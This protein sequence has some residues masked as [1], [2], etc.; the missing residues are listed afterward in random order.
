M[1]I[2]RAA[3]GVAAAVAF[4]A[5]AALAAAPAWAAPST[6]VVQSAVLRIVSVADWSEAADLLPGES[7]Q[8]DVTVSADADAEPGTVTLALSAT[9][10]APLLVDAELC[11]QPW[12]DGACPGGASVLLTSWAIPRDGSEAV[13]VDFPSTQ[14]AHLR[15]RMAL[16]GDDDRPGFT[17]VR[18][19]AR[20]VGDA[21]T[22]GAG[23]GLAV[24]GGTAPVGA[25]IGGG[26]LLGA[27]TVL[28]AG[29]IRRRRAENA[30]QA[31]RDG[32]DERGYAGS[33]P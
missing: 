19:S 1:T 26:A 3:V 31:R 21:V 33:A 17:D 25:L 15:L 11:L 12:T 9:G 27:G 28:L 7:V 29:R 8:W 22:A 30:E 20:G 4:A 18:V 13:L 32:G 24:T 5:A 10:A 6:E 14:T 23:G 2:S 16:G